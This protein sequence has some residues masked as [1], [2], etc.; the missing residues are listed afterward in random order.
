MC[1]DDAAAMFPSTLNLIFPPGPIVSGSTCHALSLSQD[2]AAKTVENVEGGELG[3]KVID[4]TN[5]Q[6]WTYT[7]D[8]N[9]GGVPEGAQA[10][11]PVGMLS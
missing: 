10:C 3:T 6:Q 2:F 11:G 8:S 5:N 9:G 7:I 1:L 4:G